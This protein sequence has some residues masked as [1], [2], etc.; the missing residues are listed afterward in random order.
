[1]SCLWSWCCRVRE[2]SD[3]YSERKEE[4]KKGKKK[5]SRKILGKKDRKNKKKEEQQPGK[6]EEETVTLDLP[7]GLESSSHKNVSAETLKTTVPPLTEESDETV[8]SSVKT[9]LVETRME[10]L[11]GE[12]MR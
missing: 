1:M 7:V 11:L 8:K 12:L 10:Q 3:T 5:K 2:D 6:V 4:K 9:L